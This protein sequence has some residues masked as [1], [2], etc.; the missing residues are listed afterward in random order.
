MKG[1]RRARVVALQ[2]LYEIDSVA[3]RPETVLKR[4]LSEADQSEENTIFIRGLVEGVIRIVI[5]LA[6]IL[7]ISLMPDLRRVFQYHG[8]EHKVI[9]AYEACGRPD[10]EHA[11]DYPPRHPR[12]GTGFLLVVMVVAITSTSVIR[13][14]PKSRTFAL[15]SSSIRM[16]EG[17]RSRWMTPRWWA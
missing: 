11:V 2:A 14:K 1:R 6:Y 10:A 16:F 8:A 13:A 5:F 3:R 4:L 9:H 12:C 17:F 15:P 7:A